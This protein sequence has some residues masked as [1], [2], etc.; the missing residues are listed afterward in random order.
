MRRGAARQA[1][2]AQ[3]TPTEFRNLL[4]VAGK[5]NTKDRS[6]PIHIKGA[7]CIPFAAE[8]Q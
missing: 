5:A 4:H 8:N 2:L 7:L 1:Y 3:S 6:T